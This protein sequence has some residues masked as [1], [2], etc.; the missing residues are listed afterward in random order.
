MSNGYTLIELLVA[1]A[2]A[3]IL[4]TAAYPGLS[5][6]LQDS[7]RDAVVTAALHAMHAARQFAAMRAVSVELCGSVDATHCSG[8]PDWS[9]GLLIVGED[10]TVFRSLP[11]LRS[12]GGPTV[13]SNRAAIR[14]EPGTSYASPATVTICDR[15]GG[16]AARAIIVSRSGRPRVSERDASNRV[17][18]C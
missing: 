14:F 12:S 2:L 5:A 3:A 11:S 15:R 1:L 4:A 13:K 9:S 6:W 18:Q 16:R 17:L 10:G 8:A 7:R